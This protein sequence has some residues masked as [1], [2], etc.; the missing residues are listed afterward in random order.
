MDHPL[1][2]CPSQ[3]TAATLPVCIGH[4][5]FGVRDDDHATLHIDV[6]FAATGH[7]CR[8]QQKG[9]R[10][11]PTPPSVV[12]VSMPL[13]TNVPC[14]PHRAPADVATGGSRHAATIDIVHTRA[15]CV[16]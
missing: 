15:A 13:T 2:V 6:E 3:A 1:R 11:K 12:G 5:V 4:A 10:P 9:R 8:L 7:S 14:T 16:A